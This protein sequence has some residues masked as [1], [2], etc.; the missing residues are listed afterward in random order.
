LGGAPLAGE[1]IEADALDAPGFCDADLARLLAAQPRLACLTLLLRSNL[2]L[3][4]LRLVTGA[5]R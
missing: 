4:A 1:E 3:A 5:W 2:S